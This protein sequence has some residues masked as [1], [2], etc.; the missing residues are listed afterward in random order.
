MAQEQ[1]V[2]VRA[3][4]ILK[5]LSE[6]R[7]LTEEPITRHALDLT[8][9]ARTAHQHDILNRTHRSL[10]QYLKLEGDL[11]YIGLLGHFSTGKSST[12][13][14]V[15]NTWE[16][17]DERPTDLNPTDDT[18]S[19]ITRPT[20]ERY[21][22]G[23]IREGTVTIRSKPIDNPLLDSI[24]FV[25]TPG[26]G[27]PELVEEIARDFL[28]IC[29]VILFFFSAASPLDTNDMPLLEELH[30]RLQF[31]PVHFIVTRA[32][33]LRRDIFA[34]ASEENI[35]SAKRARFFDDVFRIV[36]SANTLV[37]WVNE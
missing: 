6:L 15:L 36:P 4:G 9:N 33:E 18:I 25:D 19:L 30:K 32:D 37:R 13:N 17:E 28:P 29:D 27:D 7:A 31:V 3:Q 20:N 35:D 34:P 1:E 21:L 5:G 10:T 22:L 14:S 23:V 24:V 11:F 16:T 12:I 8:N 2:D 26:T